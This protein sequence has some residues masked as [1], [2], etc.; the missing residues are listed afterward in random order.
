M[1][2][3]LVAMAKRS[4]TLAKVVI[5]GTLTTPPPMPN[6]PAATPVRAPTVATA[7]KRTWSVVSWPLD[8]SLGGE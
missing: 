2:A 5:K 3:E 1:A 8:W 6:R 7:G 4:G